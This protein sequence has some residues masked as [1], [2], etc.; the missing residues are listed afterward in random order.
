MKFFSFKINKNEVFKNIWSE[1]EWHGSR[2]EMSGEVHSI[3]TLE[4]LRTSQMETFCKKSNFC[5]KNLKN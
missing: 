3:G 5:S 1:P 4:F 2:W